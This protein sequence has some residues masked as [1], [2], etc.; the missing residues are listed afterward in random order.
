MAPR[1]TT[2]AT[3]RSRPRC[4]AWCSTLFALAH[5]RQVE[6]V[7]RKL[8]RHERLVGKVLAARS[9]INLQMV[10]RGFAWH[11]KQYE[12]E[13]ELD[14]RRLYAEAELKAREQ[15]LGLWVG[16]AP[17]PPWESRSTRGKRQSR[18]SDACVRQ[19]PTQVS[20]REQLGAHAIQNGRSDRVN[21]G[22]WLSGGCLEWG[23][24]N[25]QAHLPGHDALQ[26]LK[27]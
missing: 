19:A 18:E 20:A 8:D 25:G 24:A 23:G 3:A 16:K 9:D 11:Y 7:G 27:N 17:M 13:Q 6:V 5:D 15:S 4:T 10:L 14:D 22:Q 1:S 12:Q 21:G 2:S 26:P